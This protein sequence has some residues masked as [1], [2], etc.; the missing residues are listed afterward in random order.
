[1][2][3]IVGRLQERFPK[4]RILVRLDGGFAEPELFEFLDVVGVDYVV[5]MAKNKVLEREAELDMIV[6]QIGRAHV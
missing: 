1:M 4:A 3:R 2:K 5:A 6:A